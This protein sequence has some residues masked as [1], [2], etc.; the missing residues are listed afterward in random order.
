MKAVI[1]ARVSTEEQKDAGNSLPAQ[2]DRLKNYCKRQSFEIIETFSFDES[3]YKTKRDEFDKVLDFLK[4]HKEKVAIC[5]DKV[6]RLS[7]NVFDKRVSLLYDKAVADEIELHFVSDGQVVGPSM[8]AVEKFHFGISLGLAK[9]YSDAISDN[10]NRVFEQKR[11]QGQWLSRAL[12]GYVYITLNDGKRDL[13]PDPER[14][15]LLRKLFELYGTGNYS[16]NT[17]WQEMKTLGLRSIKGKPIARS[18]VDRIL[19]DPFYYGM[20]RSKK[21]GLYPHRYEPL[22]TKELFDKCQDVMR[23]RGYKPSKQASRPYVL[24]GLVTCKNCGCL[25]T[26]EI[27]KGKFIYYSCTNAK[28]N[29]K[30]VYVS[31]KDLLQPVY[32]VFKAF[33]G[34]SKGVQERLVSELRSL[35]EGETVFHQKEIERVRA[36]YDRIQ[37]RIDALLDMRLDQS[38]T[39]DDYDKKLQELKDRQHQLGIELEEYTKADHQ[40]HIHVSTVLDLSRRMGQIFDSSEPEEKRSILN[41]I[42]QNPTAIGKKLSFTLK[43]PFDSVLSLAYAQTENRAFS[44]ACPV[45]GGQWDLHPQ[46]RIK[47]RDRCHTRPP[48]DERLH[49]RSLG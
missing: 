39:H 48:R 17:L 14:A 40:Y 30:R 36:E 16:L 23:G 18:S 46:S 24:K 27:K 29:C 49:K 1:L 41:F 22:I 34:I 43:K 26:P 7:R 11:R 13:A 21:H 28:H 3:A 32:G 33:G 19:R 8:S 9:Y 5:F 35:S 12:I 10:V 42:L 2:I 44:P 6:D 37:K 20:V 15:H 38:I 4:T 25:Y 45:W 31:E 47:V